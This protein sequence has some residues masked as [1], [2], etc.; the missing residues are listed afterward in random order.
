MFHIKQSVHIRRKITRPVL[1][2]G[3]TLTT[4]RNRQGRWLV[5]SMVAME[6]L[7][8]WNV[9]TNSLP[10]YCSRM[11]SISI[12]VRC[13]QPKI[14]YMGYVAVV[15]GVRRLCRYRSR[16]GFGIMVGLTLKSRKTR[17]LC[18]LQRR[19]SSYSLLILATEW[20]RKINC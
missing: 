10:R 5:R 12:R 15:R 1:C 14:I 6:C 4:R 18:I 7:G 13:G 19:R 9:I 11:N 2:I 16:G 17:N 3:V 8:N 20:T